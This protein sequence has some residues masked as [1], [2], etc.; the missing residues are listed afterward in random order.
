M[1]NI[2]LKLWSYVS[3]E[4]QIKTK[5]QVRSRVSDLVRTINWRTLHYGMY[6]GLIDN[7]WLPVIENLKNESSKNK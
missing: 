5:N 7:T 4:I 2:E 1:N 6:T 3:N